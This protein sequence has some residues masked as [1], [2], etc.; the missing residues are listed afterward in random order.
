MYNVV[1]GDGRRKLSESQ[2]KEIL[3]LHDAG[4][5][6][7]SI[8]KKFLVSRGTIQFICYPERVVAMRAKAKERKAKVVKND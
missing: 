6:I 5:S 3:D 1:K 2:K 8:S 4:A 7:R